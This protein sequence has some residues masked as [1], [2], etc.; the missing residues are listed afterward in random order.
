LNHF[1]IT[2]DLGKENYLTAI[3]KGCIYQR[4][5][6]ANI[7]EIS[8]D[9]KPFD[10]YQGSYL[11]DSSY[12]YF[13]EGSH[14]FMLV[15]LYNSSFT[16]LLIAKK[17]NHFFYFVDN[18]FAALSLPKGIDIFSLKMQN[19][20]VYN[21]G[22]IVQSFSQAAFFLSKG[23]NI[24][25]FTTP[26][27]LQFSTNDIQP[28]VSEEYISA[29]V[30]F[31][32]RFSNVVINITKNQFNEWVGEKS[33]EIVFAGKESVIKISNGYNDVGIGRKLCFFNNAGYLELAVRGGNA[34]ELFGMDTS[35]KIDE[36]YRTVKIFLR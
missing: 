7:V 34:A 9:V 3:V 14:H 4:F 21:V 33:F 6:Q 35:E 28:I 16:N 19:D 20:F 32:D 8:S 1:T 15:G 12:K 29:Q 26:Y 30:L 22:G 25:E 10:V 5:S 36:M 13:P 27:E 31:I 23:A 17:D 11:L 2:S 18:G 24:T